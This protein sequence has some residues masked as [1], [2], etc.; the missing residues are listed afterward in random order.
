MGINILFAL[1]GGV[2]GDLPWV[3]F[4]ANLGAPEA[5]PEG[6]I[7]RGLTRLEGA[8]YVWVRRQV[9]RNA[10]QTPRAEA[11]C[12]GLTGRGE[13]VMLQ[14]ELLTLQ[15]AHETKTLWRL[16]FRLWHC[17][18][19]GLRGLLKRGPI[20]RSASSLEA[21]GYITD[22]TARRRAFLW[23]HWH[24]LRAYSITPTGLSLAIRFLNAVAASPLP[25]AKARPPAQ[26]A[27]ARLEDKQLAPK[28]PLAGRS[29]PTQ[30]RG[31]RC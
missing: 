31:A 8:G 28:S 22:H 23:Q 12:A 3:T 24:A 15:A 1:Q 11:C 16:V 5:Q 9:T 21:S 13:A 17:T 7:R 26:P 4:L 6:E 25:A 19:D 2:V 10:Q 30:K 14:L 29:I 18:S 20:R 27:A